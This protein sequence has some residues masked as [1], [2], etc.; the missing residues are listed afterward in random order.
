MLDTGTGC[1]RTQKLWNV[2][3]SIE[4]LF[5]FGLFNLTMTLTISSMLVEMVD[6]ASSIVMTVGRFRELIW[7]DIERR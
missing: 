2:R 3:P 5:P 6:V 7:M 4:A 1:I